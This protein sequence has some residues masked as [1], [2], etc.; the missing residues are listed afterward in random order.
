MKSIQVQRVYD[1]PSAQRGTRF[2]VDRLWPRG[3]KKGALSLDGWLKD[4]APSDELR[5]WFAHEPA[6]WPE[7][8]RRY[9]AELKAHPDAVQP[10]LDA[11]IRGQ[12]T[13][14]FGA[15]DSGHN[16]AVALREYL[17]ARLGKT[18]VARV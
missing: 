17:E 8:R 18:A 7:F 2:L 10:I 11:A 13:L 5:R 3:V 12:V 16:N 14:L 4:A 1:A 15:T 6:K 9:F